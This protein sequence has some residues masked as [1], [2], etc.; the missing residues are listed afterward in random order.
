[1]SI[2]KKTTTVVSIP[3]FIVLGWVQAQYT[4]V[5]NSNRPGIAVSAYSVGT[6]VIQAEGGF[7][8]ETRDHSLLNQQSTILGGEFALRYGFLFEQL[9]VKY[10]ATYTLEEVTY[11]NFGFTES[12][13]DF[14]RNRLGL[15]FLVY[16]PFKNPERNKPNLYSW[17]ANHKFKFKNLLPA[18]SVYGGANFNLGDNLYYIEDGSISY[19]GMIAMQSRLTPRS[20]LIINLAYDRITTDFPEMSYAISF[21]RS[22]RNPK[23][24][25]FLEHQAIQSDRFADGILRT[26]IAHLLGPNFQV[27]ISAGAGFKTTPSRYFARTGLSYRWDFHKDKM[28]ATNNENPAEF[29]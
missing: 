13:N 16:D 8:Y 17:K 24:S 2:L 23:W 3:F 18:I 14:R 12:R 6:G 27:D 15:K 7:L 1:M 28:R 26:G 10:E 11:S 9:E 19:R 22:F 5:I 25:F 29:D 20:V 4:D 21:S